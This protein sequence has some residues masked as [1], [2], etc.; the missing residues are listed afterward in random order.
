M[1]RASKA[2]IPETMEGLRN[3]NRAMRS[4]LATQEEIMAGLTVKGREYQEA[5]T[6]LDSEREANAIL[7]ARVDHLE[8]A[9]RALAEGNLGDRSWQANYD[10]IRAHA[11]KALTP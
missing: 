10:R 2:P 3:Q 8:A 7:T 4:L 5:I 6:T 11:V 1:S 9:L